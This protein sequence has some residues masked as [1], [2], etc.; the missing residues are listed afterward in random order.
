MRKLWLGSVLV[1][2]GLVLGCGGQSGLPKK[3]EPPPKETAGK[4]ATAPAIPPPPGD[5]TGEKK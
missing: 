5:K 3:T 4:E 2:L 1:S